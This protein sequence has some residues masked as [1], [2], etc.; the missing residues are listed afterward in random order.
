MG[1]IVTASAVL[2]LAICITLYSKYED[3]KRAGMQG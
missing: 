1:A 3:K 2:L